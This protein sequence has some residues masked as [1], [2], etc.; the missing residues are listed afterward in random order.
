MFEFLRSPQFNYVFSFLIGLG[1]VS[2]F[3]SSCK[4]DA[5][6]ILRAPPYEEL[7]TSTYQTGK[8]CYKFHA[9]VI[10]CPK[11]GVIEPFERFVR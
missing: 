4:G 1:I 2:L 5:C 9:G 6:R 10:E 3:K 11:V 8:D 7:K